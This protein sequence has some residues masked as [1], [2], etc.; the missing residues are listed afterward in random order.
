MND[1]THK[2]F[3]RRI[4]VAEALVQVGDPRTIY[5]IE[6]RQIPKGDVFEMAK[7]AGLLAIKNTAGVI[8]DCHPLPVE[9]AAV[10]S[11]VEGMTIRIEVEVHTVYRTGV[12]VEAMHGAAIAALTMYDML[13]PV[14]KNVEIGHVRLLRKKGGKSQFT[15]HLGLGLKAA[16]VV[17]SD[18]VSA[19]KKDDRAGVAIQT[20]LGDHQVM[21]PHYVVIPDEPEEI[22]RAF[23][24]FTDAEPVDLLLM[25]G[26]TGLSPR[27]VTPETIAPL[28]D[29]EI[30]GIMEAARS[31]GQD[32]TPYAMLSRGVAGMKGRTLVITLPGSTGGATET[33][34]AL[35]PYVL[36][37]FRVAQGMRH[38][39][40]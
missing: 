15:D 40:G 19:G 9:Y 21:V 2:I 37:L 24:R 30:P 7:A 26:G 17:C 28:L 34:D 4:A 14:D 1:I 39:E 5:R 18:S 31:F 6:S 25:T 38:D 35:F 22:R 23:L 32:R 8:P 36:H 10:R 3:T 16:V 11:A 12:E 33:M 27:D 13:K 20:R 29:R